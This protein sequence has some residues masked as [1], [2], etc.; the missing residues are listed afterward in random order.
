MQEGFRNSLLVVPEYVLPWSM[1]S[2]N[3]RR[4]DALQSLI[5]VEVKYSRVKA[6]QL[7]SSI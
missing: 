3:F 2:Y 6:Q 5:K 1:S 7:L 4:K